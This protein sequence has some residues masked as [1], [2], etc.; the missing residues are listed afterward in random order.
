V[1][2]VGAGIDVHKA[3]IKVCLFWRDASGKRQQEVRTYR[4]MTGDLLAMRDWL[5]DHHCAVVALESTGVYWRPVHNL[6]EGDF[7]VLLVNPTHIQHVPGRKTD[8]KACQWLAE[9]LE[10]GLRKGSFIPPLEMRDLRDLTR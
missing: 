9:L 2:A 6:L 4:T 5:Q 3:D 8:V 7:Q 1:H 10:H